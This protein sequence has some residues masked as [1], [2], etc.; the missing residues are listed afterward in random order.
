MTLNV[1]FVLILLA[2]GW[3]PAHAGLAA[4]TSCA[5]LF[6]AALLFAG[7]RAAGVYRAGGAWPILLARVAAACAAMAAF[8]L[9]ALGRTGDWLALGAWQRVGVLAL[10][11]VGGTAVY[12]GA[13]FG[14]GL[15]VRE[16]RAAR[17]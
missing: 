2:T 8:L 12:F 5:A 17:A 4:A 1:A 9:W 3:A 13:A 14:L 16:L 15:R 7:L 11:V 6:N 10:L